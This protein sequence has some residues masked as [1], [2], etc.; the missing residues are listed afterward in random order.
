[1]F[2]EL[3]FSLVLLFDSGSCVVWFDRFDFVVRVEVIE[4]IIWLNLYFIK[5]RCFGI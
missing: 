4:C 5:Y 2:L 1:M 3:E